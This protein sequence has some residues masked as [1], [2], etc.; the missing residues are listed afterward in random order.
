MFAAV[1]LALVL[2]PT[3]SVA[4][5]PD[6]DGPQVAAAAHAQ[7]V[8]AF[9]APDIQRAVPTAIVALN[10]RQLHDP[11]FRPI[12]NE[13][14]DALQRQGFN[15][16]GRG[17]AFRNVVTLEYRVNRDV[18][19][20]LPGQSTSDPR[21]V[22]QLGLAA[23]P[24][25][26]R[27]TVTAYT[28]KDH[29]RAEVLWRTVMAEDG[30]EYAVDKTIPPL[31]E[32]GREYFGRNLTQLAADCNDYA[33]PLGSHI[34][35]KACGEVRAQVAGG[36]VRRPDVTVGPLSTPGVPAPAPSPGR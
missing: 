4:P 24:A 17:E 10:G 22:K 23:F 2:Q 30:F 3:A 1:V 14:G 31:V 11:H 9:A 19:G 20:D 33:P 32:A 27:L 35:A 28:M 13:L 29:G 25:Y 7:N 36:V 5:Q 21:V 16:V 34:P 12:A 8:E 6:A 15:V 26:R 18:H